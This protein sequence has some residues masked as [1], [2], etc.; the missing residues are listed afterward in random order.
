LAVAVSIAAELLDV[1]ART[2]KKAISRRMITAVILTHFRL[3]KAGFR[4]ARPIGT[5]RGDA[6]GIFNS[7][8]FTGRTG[9]I[10]Y[11]RLIYRG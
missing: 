7:V 6:E 4:S 10:E 11:S 2:I 5:G 8:G 3:L 9:S 1:N